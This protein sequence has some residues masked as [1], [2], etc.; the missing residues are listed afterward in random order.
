MFQR[1][2]SVLAISVALL[3]GSLSILKPAIA[4]T[5][6]A[7]PGTALGIKSDSDLWRYVRTGNAGT[8]QMKNV[9]VQQ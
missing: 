5:Q 4:Q 8:S 7:V 3:I 6:G 9:I 2:L 1:Y